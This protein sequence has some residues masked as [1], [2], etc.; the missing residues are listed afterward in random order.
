MFNLGRSNPSAFHHPKLRTCTLPKLCA[1]AQS[2]GRYDRF[3]Q[4]EDEDEEMSEEVDAVV[5]E[6]DLRRRLSFELFTDVRH[7]PKAILLSIACV[8]QVGLLPG[9]EVGGTGLHRVKVPHLCTELG[10]L[11]DLLLGQ[12]GPV[13]QQRVPAELV[14]PDSNDDA[15]PSWK[16]TEMVKGDLISGPLVD[17]LEDLPQWDAVVLGAAGTARVREFIV[18]IVLEEEVIVVG[19]E[20]TKAAGDTR[21]KYIMSK[22]GTYY[23]LSIN[24]GMLRFS[25]KTWECVNVI[26]IHSKA[27]KKIGSAGTNV[28]QFH[29]TSPG[30]TGNRTTRD[31][32]DRSGST[33]NVF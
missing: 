10:Q 6:K 2:V 23:R 26:A 31:A 11:H 13:Q 3:I 25:T 29:G 21:L 24:R 1:R 18:A 8:L 5:D 14:A 15:A 7:E 33:N 17:S 22:S 19:K 20:K 4:E 12:E 32:S 9:C 30:K 16:P 28:E 27:Q